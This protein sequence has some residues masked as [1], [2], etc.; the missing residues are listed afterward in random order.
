VEQLPKTMMLPKKPKIILTRLRIA[1]LRVMKFLKMM[2][3]S[4]PGVAGG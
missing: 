1:M 4:P 3:S 2:H